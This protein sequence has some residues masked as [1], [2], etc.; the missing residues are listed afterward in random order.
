MRMRFAAALL[1][2]ALVPGAARATSLGIG[3]GAFGGINYPVLMD[4][5]KTGAI[6]GFRAPIRVLPLITIEPFWQSS[7]L[8]DANE[9]FGALGSQTRDGGQ[10]SSYGAN[11]AL[12]AMGSGLAVFPYVGIGSGTYKQS[13]V[14]DITK[15]TYDFGLGLMFKV[16]P[17]TALDIRGQMDALITSD[18]SRKFASATAGLTYRLPVH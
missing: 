6:Y 5:A 18:T 1:L 7:T 14:S 2:L 4:N 17:Y 12:T 15:T 16:L 10:F 13:G 8:G 9:T 3:V 11:V